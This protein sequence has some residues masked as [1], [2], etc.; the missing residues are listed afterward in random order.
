MPFL[1]LCS[2]RERGGGWRRG[3]ANERGVG[4]WALGY[5]ILRLPKYCT[6][7]CHPPHK[8]KRKRKKDHWLGTERIDCLPNPILSQPTNNFHM[9]T[10]NLRERSLK[11]S[12]MYSYSDGIFTGSYR[13]WRDVGLFK[14]KKKKSTDFLWQQKG[15]KLWR[16]GSPT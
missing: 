5:F 9:D 7:L 6:N 2:R 8:K 11:N 4:A 13:N 14:K 10:Y 12:Y 15:K 1:Y 16:F 3:D